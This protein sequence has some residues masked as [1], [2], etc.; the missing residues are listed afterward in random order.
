[1]I[2][3]LAFVATVL[4][5]MPALAQERPPEMWPG[6]NLDPAIAAPEAVIGHPIGVRLTFS[7]DIARYFD[8]LAA[9]APGR[10]VVGEYGRTHEGRRLPWAAISSPENIARLDEIRANARALSDART[11]T[12]AQAAAIIANQ[13]AIVWLA[14][15]VHGNEISPAEASMA[16]ARHLL[17]ARGD[18][19]VAEMLRNTV[20]VLVPTQNPDGRDR[21]LNSYYAGLGIRPN[22][23]YQSVERDEPWPTGRYNHDLF[24][25]NRDWF[26]QTQPETRGH[27]AIQFEWRPQVVADAHEMGTEEGFFFPP[28]ADPINPRLPHAQLMSRH[29][30]GRNHAAVFDR[31]G[32][33]YFTREVYDAYYPGYG[34][35]WSA[36]FG[37][38]SM[39]Y[40]QGS[41][42]GLTANLPGGRQLTLFEATRAH[43]L[44]SLST[45]ETAARNREK[46]LRDF[47]DQAQ[48]ALRDGRAKGSWILPRSAADPGAADNL[49][50]LLS[51][52]GVE[53]SR[54]DA[55]FS[56]CGRN[57]P[58]GT[59]IID[60]AQ[61]LGPL[62]DV[63]FDPGIE[64]EPAF[65]AEQERRRAAGLG[66]EMYDLT[67]W[68]LPLTF[69]TE[70]PN[71]RIGAVARTPL[72][73]DTVRPGGFSGGDDA[74]VYVVS[75]GQR[76]MRLLTG[77]LDQGLRV[78][79]PERAFN[80][81][82][83]DWPSGS[84]VIP[85]AG[86]PADLAARL[87]T[88]ARE[89]G[90]DVTG[91]ADTWVTE[92]PSLG[93][94][95]S[96]TL[97]APRV[98]VAWDRPSYATAAGAVRYTLERVYGYPVT[99]VR[100]ST[101]KDGDLS[102][103]DVIVLPDGGNYA[104]ALGED[105]MAALV[106]WVRNGGVLVGLAGATEMM[107]DPNAHM[108]AARA[109]MRAE[110]G[111][112]GGGASGVDISDARSYAEAIRPGEGAPDYVPGV[113]ARA[114]VD[115][116]HW[117]GAGVAPTLNVMVE[118]TDVF[119]P[120]KVGEGVNV[121]RFAAGGALVASGYLWAENRRQLAFKPVVM[122]SDL[123]EG[124]L[125]AFTE[126]PTL[127]GFMRG[128]DVLFLNAV[129]RAPAYAG[130]GR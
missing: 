115:G 46:L 86:N 107:T 57:Y 65:V 7:G 118:G 33:D 100:V 58:A 98:A 103:Y 43:F 87:R 6:A 30:F 35:S 101:L 123:G 34:D 14:Y 77:A 112:D 12:P 99:P 11:T 114:V 68:A 63:L 60:A 20:V 37:A 129:F 19:R 93:S 17:A 50:Q 45:V 8:A 41:P 126:D 28:E 71:C 56:G 54:A 109:E 90:A 89:T 122:V 9:S 125:I 5:A 31:E 59:Y 111:E 85:R 22:G 36:Y 52:Q 117:M 91:V 15:S 74:V 110:E 72:T 55:S 92:G 69:N 83:R 108:L 119:T 42:R 116:D 10:M 32:L 66:A 79:S 124:Q 75:P 23:D 49:A 106:R 95:R 94:S 96:P 97:V 39:T 113:L 130:A 47:W 53:V 3:L 128:M 61:P 27:S 25:M 2:R 62:V 21:F 13:P 24:D 44:V 1:M 76:G 102:E 88:L 81:G 4:L 40:E 127:R 70:A 105:G 73:P 29:L 26:A 120:L 121:V 104:G 80:L 38:V 16:T 82:G 67:A 51:D 48:T 78:R 84:I 64:M 18:P